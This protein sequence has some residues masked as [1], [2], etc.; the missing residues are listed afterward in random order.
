LLDL[1][2][3]KGYTPLNFYGN[4]YDAMWAIAFG[5]HTVD[6]WAGEK[7]VGTSECDGMTGELITLDKF[8][9]TNEKM[10]CYMRRAFQEVNFIGITVIINKMHNHN[11]YCAYSIQ[12]VVLIVIGSCS[13]SGRR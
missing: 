5:L 6:M 2:K 8:N 4:A 9:Y 10:G 3:Y 12:C 1:P 7:I 13:I 11:C